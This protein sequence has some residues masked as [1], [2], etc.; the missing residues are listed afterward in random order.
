MP[1]SDVI[2]IPQVRH[3]LLHL[4]VTAK[5]EMEVGRGGCCMTDGIFQCFLHLILWG[6]HNIYRD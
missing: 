4:Y 3:L 6:G 5:L 2:Q 1:G